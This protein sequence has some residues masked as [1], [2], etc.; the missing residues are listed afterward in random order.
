[1]V[2]RVFGEE[3]LILHIG[4][5]LDEEGANNVA[6]VAINLGCEVAFGVLQLLERWHTAKYSAGGQ[7]QHN[8]NQCNGGHTHHPHRL[9]LIVLILEILFYGHTLEFAL[10]SN[11][12]R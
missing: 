1:M 7:R 12:Q 9:D 10:Y 8:E 3:L 5:V 4:A 6:I 2:G 11:V